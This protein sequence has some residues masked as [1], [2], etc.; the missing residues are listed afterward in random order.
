MEKDTRYVLIF[1][2][3]HGNALCIIVSMRYCGREFTDEDVALIHKLIQDN[4]R[5]NRRKLSALFCKE[6]GWLK[7]DGGL[8]DMS[9]RVAFLR[10]HRDGHINLPAPTGPS[11][12]DK[13]C[14]KRTLLAEPQPSVTKNACALK[15]GIPKWL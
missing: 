14:P 9:C 15:Y 3:T 10:M 4:P 12:N 6:V 7:V 13:K 5:I 8:K 2:C 1:F 11:N